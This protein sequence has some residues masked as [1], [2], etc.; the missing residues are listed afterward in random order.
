MMRF[1]EVVAERCPRLQGEYAWFIYGGTGFHRS[2][3]WNFTVYPRIHFFNNICLKMCKN[4]I[5]Y[6]LS[7]MILL[8]FA[9]HFA[10]RTSSMQCQNT[11][12]A[13]RLVRPDGVRSDCVMSHRL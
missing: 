1:T 11:F 6:D 8:A 4:P 3:E 12:L 7:V 9:P 5:R 13:I 2:P 10:R